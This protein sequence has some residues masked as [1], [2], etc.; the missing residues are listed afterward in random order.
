MPSQDRARTADTSPV[1]ASYL[2]KGRELGVTGSNPVP[3]ANHRKN[4][5]SVMMRKYKSMG[6][7]CEMREITAV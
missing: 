7:N 5:E 4:F 3:P 2:G 6:Y 1:Q